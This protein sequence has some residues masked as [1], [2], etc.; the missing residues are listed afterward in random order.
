MY[1]ECVPVHGP[2]I[3]PDDTVLLGNGTAPGVEEAGL[4]QETHDRPCDPEGGLA[5]L[6][7]PAAL[8]ENGLQ[9]GFEMMVETGSEPRMEQEQRS[10]GQGGTFRFFR[11]LS[12][13]GEPWIVSPIR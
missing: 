4:L 8:L 6:K 5:L 11:K 10:G 13:R 1:R 3:P 2:D 7:T 12:Q 9:E